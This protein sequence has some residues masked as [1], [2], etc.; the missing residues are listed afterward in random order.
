VPASEILVV[1]P[2]VAN[3]IGSGRSAQIY[4]LMESGQ[5]AG[6]QTLEQDLARLWLGGVISEQAALARA[7][8]PQVLRDRVALAARRP[9]GADGGRKGATS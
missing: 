5:A 8:N 7:R 1:T 2:A 6:M 4:S 9:N 3:L